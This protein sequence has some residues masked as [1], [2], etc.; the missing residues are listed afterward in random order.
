[1][2]NFE[3]NE[4]VEIPDELP[5]LAI[6]DLVVYPYMIVPLLVSRPPHIIVDATRRFAVFTEEF[7]AVPARQIGIAGPNDSAPLLKA[8]AAARC[9]GYPRRAME[10]L[11][12][13]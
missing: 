2:T 11:C 6:R 12:H 3:E 4:L 5:M 1:M 7:L 8:C 9:G 10:T 13:C